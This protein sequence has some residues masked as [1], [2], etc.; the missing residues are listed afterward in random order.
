MT[1]LEEAFNIPVRLCCHD[2]LEVHQ[3]F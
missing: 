1:L 2:Q 3:N